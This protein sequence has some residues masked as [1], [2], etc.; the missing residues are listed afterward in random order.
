[1]AFFDVLAAKKDGWTDKDIAE[2]LAENIGFNVNAARQD[3]WGYKDIISSLNTT[4]AT[5]FETFLQS[6][7]QEVGSEVK[8]A[9]QLAG[10]ELDTASESLSR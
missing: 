4:N 3:G 9:Y 2:A 10:G 6:A 7:K 1:M 8:G 5:P